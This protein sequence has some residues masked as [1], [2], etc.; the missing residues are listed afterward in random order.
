VSFQYVVGADA[1]IEQL[2]IQ[3]WLFQARSGD[4]AGARRQAELALERLL[5]SGLPH[6]NGAQG[7]RLDPY[8]AANLIKARAG[9]LADE[10]WSAWQAT[11]RRNAVSLPR[12]PQRYEFSMRREWHGFTGSPGRPVVLRMPLP[13]RGSQRGAAHVRVLEPAGAA[14]DIRESPGRVEIRLDPARLADVVVAEVRVQFDSGDA[15][16]PLTPAAPLGAQTGADEQVWLRDR[17]GLIVL[18][19]EVRDLAATLADGCSDARQYLHAAS[20]WL[21]SELKFG[22][23]HRSDLDETNPLGWLLQTRRADCFL[24]SSL[25][26]ALCR[27]RGIPARLV[28]GFLLHPANIGPHAW[29]EARLAPDVWVPF[30]FGSWCYSAGNPDDPEWGNFYRGRV[31]ARLLAETAPREFTGWGS[32]P[33]PPRWYRLESL[34]GERIVHTLHS[35]PDNRL[36]RRDTLDLRLLGPVAGFPA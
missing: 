27:A 28:S 31:D 18:G 13:S 23:W 34:D 9:E 14:V 26:I 16:D 35:L 21:M 17:E 20:R 30:D 24:G 2:V 7:L 22:D 5:A 33:P 8:A 12:E 1:I 36:F 32:A 11:A 6:E 15:G 4:R 10:S 3:C 29:A 19:S 25:L